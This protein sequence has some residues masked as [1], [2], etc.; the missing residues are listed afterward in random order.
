MGCVD[1]KIVLLVFPSDQGG[2]KRGGERTSAGCRGGVKI[3]C[4]TSLFKRKRKKGGEI[5]RAPLAQ[6]HGVEK[7]H[8]S[9]G[10]GRGEEGKQSVISRR[11]KR[12]EGRR[13][14]GNRP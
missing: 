11:E 14:G 2:K 4:E 5:S 1:K 7:S 13:R 9:Y 12:R 8:F 6:V 10:R 3:A